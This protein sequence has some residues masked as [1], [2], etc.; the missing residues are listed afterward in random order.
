ML[1]NWVFIAGAALLTI[2][3]VQYIYLLRKQYKL[4][5]QTSPLQPL[6]RL[7]FTVVLMLIIAV[8]PLLFV[9][10]NIVWF[11]FD[12][13]WIVYAAVIA[14]ALAKVVVGLTLT[15]VYRYRG[16]DDDLLP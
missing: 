8:A 4:F 1:D 14:N 3:E 2:A 7:L 9:Y 12:N 6:K 13:I 10:L 16:P 15:L 11:H 5:S